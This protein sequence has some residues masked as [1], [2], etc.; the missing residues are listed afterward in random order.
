MK[1][2][3]FLIMMT[4]AI[5]NAAKIY[6]QT[7]QAF[8]YQAV[9]R[10]NT[11]K[12]LVSQSVGISVTLH[13]GTTTGTVVYS[14]VQTPAT[15]NIGLVNFNIGEGSNPSGNFSQIDWSSGPYFLEIGV[16]AAGGSNYISMGTSQ[17]LSVPYALYSGKTRAA[18]R[19]VV[20]G[21]SSIPADSALFVVR[22]KLGQPVFAVYETGVEVSYNMNPLKGAKGGFSVGGRSAVNGPL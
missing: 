8:K 17:L 5:V 19:L 14:E 12:P 2:F 10:D 6:S 3:F 9:I 18:D 22:D 15:T 1:K 20:E 11:G 21:N 7:P 13:Q 16:D 4:V